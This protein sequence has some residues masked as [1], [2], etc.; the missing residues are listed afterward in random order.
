MPILYTLAQCNALLPLVRAVTKEII[1][2]RQ[3]RR[4]LNRRRDELEQ[5]RSPEGLQT[6]LADLD[7]AVYEQEEGVRKSRKELE[8]LGL[9][10]LRLHPLT[11]H[12]PGQTRLGESVVFCWQEG[13][14]SV[15]HGH[16]HGEEENPRRPL[17]LRTSDSS[18]SS[19]SP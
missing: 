3:E 7:T 13:D 11:V 2:R 18:S 9:T 6:A 17:R 12:F 10:V 1:E 8:A 14:E 16:A 15:T 19:S 5:A 4:Q